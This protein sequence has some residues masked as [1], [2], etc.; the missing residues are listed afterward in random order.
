MP[1]VIPLSIVAGKKSLEKSLKKLLDRMRLNG[2]PILRISAMFLLCLN[3]C[4]S[5]DFRSFKMPPTTTSPTAATTAAP[6]VL[7]TANNPI[8]V[9]T[10]LN[11]TTLVIPEVGDITSYWSAPSSCYWTAKASQEPS[12]SATPY[13]ADYIPYFWQYDY[14]PGDDPACKP[15][16]YGAVSAT[17]ASAYSGGHAN[18][19]APARSR[20]MVY[21]SN[22]LR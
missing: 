2:C 5:L 7:S 16:T 8:E 18:C 17:A 14:F 4:M 20:W 19:Y 6:T 10:D 15:P 1:N 3:L 22:Y 13:P 11:S 21:C 9:S 12:A